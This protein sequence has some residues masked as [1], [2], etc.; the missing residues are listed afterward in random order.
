MAFNGPGG[1]QGG[2]HP[3]QDLPSG[4][5]YHLPPHEQEEEA[6]RYLLNEPGSHGYEHDRLG[7]GT[8]PDRPV[9]AYSLTESYAPGAS[10]I[11]TPG[12]G[13]DS[14]YGQYG[15]GAGYDFP[16][17]A[18]TVHD[19][20]DDSWVQRQQQPA[21]GGLKR[22]NT[23]KVK[24]VQ[25]SVLSIDYPVP[26]AIKNAVQP[27]YRDVEGGNEEFVKMRYTAATCDPNDFTLKNGYDLRP[28]M[29]N[30]HTEL[31]I[32]ITYYNEDKVLLARTLHGVM[33]N[34]R[35]I[36]NLKKSTF[37]N[38]GG[39]AWQ[40]IVVC[41]VFDGIEKADKNTLDVL[42]T[43][44]VYQDGVVKKDVDGKETVAHI[45]EYTSQ[46]SVTPNQQLIRPSGD[47]PQNLPPVQFIFCLKQQNTKKI[48]SH[49]WLFNAFGRILNPEVCILLDA[50]TKPSPRSLLAL[51]EGFYNDK[52][53]GGACGEIHAMLGKG[54]KKLLNPLV[55]VQNFEYKISNI[56]DKPLE[57]SFGYVSVLP[58]AFSAYRFRAIMGRPLEQYFHGDHTLS[59]ILGKKGIDGMNIFKKNMFLAE[60]RILCFELVAKAGQKWHLTYIKAAKGETD[61]PEGAAEFISQRRRWLNGSFAASLYA[62]MHFGRMYKSGHNIIRMFFLHI[63]LIYNFLNVIFSWFS[64]ASY[65]LTTT[66]IMDLV[67]TPV[68]ASSNSS[69]H[70]GW[71]FGDEATPIINTLLKYLYLA[72]VILQFILA[73]GNR[74]KGSK[75]TYIA[76]FMVFALI[77]GYI[78]VLSV[79]LVVQAFN[80]PIQDQINFDSGEDFVKS[81]FFG[82]GAAG[83]IIIA[84]ITIY[85]LYFIA[86]FLYL[87]PWHMFHSFPHYLLLMSTYINILM[88]YAFNNWHDVSWG[89]KGSDKAEALPSANVQKGEKNEVVVEEIEKEQEDID[90]QFEQTVRRALAP[91]KE[92]EEI[93]KKD[94]EDGYKS[95]RTGLVVSWLFSNIILIIGVTTDDFAQSGF[96]GTASSRTANFFKFLLYATAVLSLIRFIG[97]LWFLG[98]TGLMCCFA[99]RIST[100]SGVVLRWLTFYRM[101]NVTDLSE[102]SLGSTMKTEF[103]DPDNILN[104]ILSIEPDEGMYRGGRFTF[105]FAINQ[106]FPHEPPKVL[107]REKIYHPNIDLEGKV[108]LN[109]LREDWKPVLNLNAVIVGLQF[110]F[111]E[112]NASD[113]LNKEAADDLRSNREGF[114]R[115]VRTAMS[116]GSVKGTVYDRV[117]K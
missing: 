97:F 94:V 15:Q 66:V 95:F 56:L 23:R 7:A 114:K 45:F 84:L 37:W 51:W 80:T 33:Q 104:F 101:A 30:R 64:L 79:F 17:P 4:S 71:P 21:G 42:A 83:V 1:G 89:T 90:S 116:G 6:G 85:G 52:D 46:L 91:F 5:S 65:Y 100:P 26:S 108:C 69:E 86:S 117:L 102:L 111:L 107:C 68:I 50:G 60:D 54:G 74:P 3:L 96:V 77:Q 115:N 112:P 44:G 59:K 49:R 99:R 75:F 25:G 39:P 16:R 19:N 70:H 2:G 43:I 62:L 73:L 110:L 27:H 76:S 41:F 48:N 32:A 93:E 13:S 24:L 105:D 98:K 87:D 8:P 58:G 113:P 67:G 109:I 29:Y 106:N 36:V 12:L 35:D 61:V 10:P 72:F 63:Q 53:L 20:D 34:I 47:S 82:A 11:G 88:V 28:R 103:P 38:K 18:S 92:E 57:S 55:A 81:F 31:L 14:G 9:S 22:Y 78:L 40:K